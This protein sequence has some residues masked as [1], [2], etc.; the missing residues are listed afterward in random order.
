MPR[1]NKP[2]E[3]FGIERVIADDC[4]RMGITR[5]QYDAMPLLLDSQIPA[6][7]PPA[8]PAKG[9]GLADPTT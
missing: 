7:Q 6:L 5:E 3:S 1:S 4:T 8:S 2:K 9:A